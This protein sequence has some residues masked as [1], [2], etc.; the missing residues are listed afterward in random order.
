MKIENRIDLYMD[1]QRN[2]YIPTRS[3]MQQ[4]VMRSSELKDKD[5]EPQEFMQNIAPWIKNQNKDIDIF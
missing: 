2:K 3:M 1:P 5:F 4:L